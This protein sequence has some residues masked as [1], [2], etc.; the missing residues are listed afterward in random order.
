MTSMSDKAKKMLSKI[1]KEY[2]SFIRSAQY[3]SNGE[4]IHLKDINYFNT[5]TSK[6]Q[7]NDKNNKKREHIISSIINSETPKIFFIKSLRWFNLKKAIELYISKL[8]IDNDIYQIDNIS[9]NIK[10]GRKNNYD[11]DI[12]I[13]DIYHFDIE[14]KFNAKKIKEAPQFVSPMKLSQ[15][16]SNNFE[17]FYYD[18]YLVK[19]EE[20][21][22]INIPEKEEY[23]SKVHSPNPKCLEQIQDRYY[24][25]CKRSSKFTNN[26]DD[27]EFYNYMKKISK[28]SISDFV[29]K[30][31]INIDKLNEYL[32][33][34]Q[35]NKKYMLYKNKSLYFEEHNSDDYL[36]KSCKKEPSLSR[37]KAKTESGNFLKILI[38]WKNGNGVAF[39][40]FQI[41]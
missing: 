15:Y 11:F 28:D 4:E 1:S 34:S 23:L 19:L 5:N 6:K 14:F 8:A 9:C 20:K 22:G 39:P 31:D 21:Y 17:E 26:K 30:N 40:A 25:G 10:A 33:N 18:L 24:K 16:L 3:I 2:L 36:I 35:K 38:R 29:S 41:S 27:I 37:Y 12:V 32:K 7:K 13:N